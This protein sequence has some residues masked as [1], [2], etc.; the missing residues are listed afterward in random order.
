MLINTVILLLR[1]LLPIV[2]LLSYLRAFITPT[3]FSLK[4]MRNIAVSSLL[5]VLLFIQIVEPI[6]EW[7]NGT[8]LELIQIGFISL[9]FCLLSVVTVLKLLERNIPLSVVLASI[10][11]EAFIVIKTSNF[12]VFLHVYLQDKT[13]F[14][15]VLTGVILGLGICLSAGAIFYYLLKEWQDSSL[16]LLLYLLWFLFLAGMFS[17]V[18]P[19]LAQIDLV[20][21]SA[22]VWHSEHIIANGSEYGQLLAA[23][24]GYQSAP[25]LEYLWLYGGIFLVLSILTLALQLRSKKAQGISDE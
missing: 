2:I 22:P 10:A 11:M 20:T 15:N 6:S 7:F 19:L 12:F 25:S 17:Q 18:L 23:L 16:N 5:F 24:V 1:D 3:A 4:N 8:G 13:Q 21:L 14:I 9:S